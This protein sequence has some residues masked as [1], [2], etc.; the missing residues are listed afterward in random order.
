MQSVF[1]E[2]GQRPERST[3][4]N[5]NFSSLLQEPALFGKN[6]DPQ[7]SGED[8]F[9]VF[10]VLSFLSEYGDITSPDIMESRH[11]DGSSLSQTGPEITK[12]IWQ[13]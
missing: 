10:S 6:S 11:R 3:D 7:S 1:T 4:I 5:T 9:L 8:Y 12:M 13:N 2:Q